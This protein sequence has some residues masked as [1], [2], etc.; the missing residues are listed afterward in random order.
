VNGGVQ[1]DG[2]MVATSHPL[3][4]EAGIEMLEAGGTAADAAVAA[5]AVLTVVDPRSTSIGGD[6]FGLVWPAGAAAPVALAGAGPS[7]ATLSV[8]AIRAAGFEQM[9]KI[10]PWTVTVP[11][12]VSA[13]ERLLER[14]GRLGLERVLQPAIRLAEGGFAV[15]PIIAG[16]WGDAQQ[17]LTADETAA[18]LFLPGG[19]APNAGDRL[20]NPELGGVL[21]TLARDGASAFYEGDLAERIGAAVDAAG[22]PLRAGDLAAWKGAQWVDPISRRY[23]DVD[24]YELPPPGQGIVVLEALGIFAGVECA[25]LLDEEHAAIESLKIAFADAAAHV[26]DPD[27]VAVPTERLLGE[28]H[29]AAGRARIDMGS[30]HGSVAGRATDTIYV[31]V[32]DGEGTGCSFI[33][34]LY[35]GFGSGIAVPGTGM[36]LQNRGTNF[37]LDDGHPNQAAGGKRPYHT[38]IPAILGDAGGFLGCL[39]VVGGFMQPQGQMQILRHVLD[40]G[41]GLQEAVDAPRVRYLRDRRIG[42]E[43]GYRP[44]LAEGL[45]RRGHE[46]EPLGRFAGGGAQAILARDGV[47]T[48]ASDKRKDGRALGC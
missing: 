24:V 18:R 45:A 17:R 43:D 33:Q 4:A 14:F 20:A 47:L 48:G 32:V 27:V 23:R 29:L 25:D 3:A 11:G 46:L 37:V 28:A 34:S 42:V 10:G 8:E 31:A 19:R 6:A 26:A 41:M 35:E 22:G 15:A 44:D 12:S 13:W 2:G 5:A 30:A 16:E 39:G 1:A 9:P 36:L 7:A 38:I 40:H 21:R